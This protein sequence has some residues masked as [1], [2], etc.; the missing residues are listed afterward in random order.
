MGLFE[1][2]C[3]PFGL[4]NAPASFQRFMNRTLGS[5]LHECAIAYLDDVIIYSKT[6]DEHLQHVE[7]VLTRL[8]EVNLTMKGVK[9]TFGKTRVNYLGFIVDGHGYRPD[10]GKVVAVKDFPTPKSAVQ[11]RTFLGLASYYRRFIANFSKIAKP[12]Q[13]MLRGNSAFKWE[14]DQQSAFNQLKEK[15]TTGPILAYPDFERPFVL[16]CDA[17]RMGRGAVLS[18]KDKNGNER[19]IQY[20]SR[21]T[22]EPETRYTIYK[23]EAACVAWAVE[24]CRPYLLQRDFTIVT[25]NDAV[26]W[27][28]GSQSKHHLARLAMKL[29]EFAPFKVLHRPVSADTNADAL[30]R[31]P[32]TVTHTR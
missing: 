11:L 10:P 13:D 29:Q 21:V 8:G 7:K 17:S 28:L 25:D 1:F 26:R 3:L 27:L 12:L 19:V 32:Q 9:C 31:M 22:S 6:W 23:L 20:M 15:L 5:Y 24:L 4:C 16:Q 30:S 2:N 18:Q 14:N